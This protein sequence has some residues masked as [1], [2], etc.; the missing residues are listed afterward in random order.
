MN[1]LI[2]THLNDIVIVLSKNK[3]IIKMEKVLGERQNSKFIM[4]LIKKVLSGQTPHSIAVVN[5]PGSFTGVRLGVTIAKSL[6]YAMD[7]PIKTISTLECLAVSV[8]KE[9]KIVGFSDKNGYYIGV[10]NNNNDLIGRY[11]Y[12]SNFEMENYSKTHNIITDIEINYEK[13]LEFLDLKNNI[14]AHEVNPFYIK[15]IDVEK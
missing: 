14:N 15:K 9:E 10:F 7:I 11:E 6:A 12:I 13:V 8:T 3:K 1:L 2:D 4:P 5:G